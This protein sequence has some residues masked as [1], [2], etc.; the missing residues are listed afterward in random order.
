MPPSSHLC[1]P[2]RTPNVY[3]F[4][5]SLRNL[6]AIPLLA[7]ACLAQGG[8]FQ[9]DKVWTVHLTFAQDQYRALQPKNRPGQ[10][11]IDFGNPTN[12]PIDN[13]L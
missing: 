12:S 3:G 6:L 2:N 4:S 10:H 13:T 7:G 5:M 9:T 11:G 8:L 1:E